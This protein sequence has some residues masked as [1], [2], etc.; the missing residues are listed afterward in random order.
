MR[1]LVAALVAALASSA[2][3]LDFYRELGVG[4]RASEADIKTA[5]RNLA[6]KYHPDKNKEPAAEAKFRRVQQA[7]E[8]LSDREKRRQYDQYG[9]D[10][11]NIERQ[12]QQ[13]QRQQHDF[14]DPF[15]QYRRRPQVQ[16]RA[17]PA[18]AA[19]PRPHDPPTP[20]AAAAAPVLCPS[21]RPLISRA[22][23]LHTHRV[24][25]AVAD[26]AALLIDDVADVG[27][28]PRPRRGGRRFVAPSLLPRLERA[29]QGVP[30][31]M[32]GARVQATAHGAA[33]PRLHRPQL[34]CAARERARSRTPL[35]PPAVC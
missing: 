20:R 17:E 3:A 26:A 28:V 23:C 33:R 15:N 1:L 14:F 24:S 32:G 22:P 21:G 6:K 29:M 16:R 10:Y 4:R 27:V 25:R 9:D 8:T 13:R 30:P 19:Q 11:E 12:H 34:R 35:P 2:S 7:Y 31:A 5:Y 18:A